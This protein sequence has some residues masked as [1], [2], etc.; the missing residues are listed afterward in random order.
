M[1]AALREVEE[2][3]GVKGELLDHVGQLEFPSPEGLVRA[4]YFLV[5]FAANPVPREGRSLRLVTYG[6]ARQLLAHEDARRLLETAWPLI[7]RHLQTSA[8]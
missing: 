6:E 8:P 5:R 4:E 7:D 1:A 3:A 2:E